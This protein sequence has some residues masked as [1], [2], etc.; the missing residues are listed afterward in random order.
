MEITTVAH[1]TVISSEKEK[2]NNNNVFAIIKVDTMELVAI[3]HVILVIMS[4]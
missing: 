4:T 1:V 2:E 3:K